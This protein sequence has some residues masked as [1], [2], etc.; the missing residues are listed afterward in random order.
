MLK[1]IDAVAAAEQLPHFRW[2]LNREGRVL[3]PD[4]LL[5]MGALRF[6]ARWCVGFFGGCDF[7]S[8]AAVRRT[9]FGRGGTCRISQSPE[10]LFATLCA[11]ENFA[12]NVSPS[13][14]VLGPDREHLACPFEGDFHTGQ[15]PGIKTVRNHGWSPHPA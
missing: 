14:M 13:P 1:D 10:P 8:S 15:R 9:E 6:D 7:F 4:H 11:F 3:V 12:G 2:M 5:R